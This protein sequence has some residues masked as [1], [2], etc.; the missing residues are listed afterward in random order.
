MATELFTLVAAVI[1]AIAG[2]IAVA[3]QIV[4]Q[5]RGE[6]RTAYREILHPLVPVLAENLHNLLASARVS[7]HA[8]RGESSRKWM[9][10]ATEARDE[11]KRV[12]P[13]LR[14][15]LE[16]VDRAV[17]QLTRLPNWLDQFSSDKGRQ[18]RLFDAADSLRTEIDSVVRGCYLEGRSPTQG[19]R[20]KLR[21]RC[22]RYE[23]IKG[24]VDTEKDD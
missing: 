16:G 14:Y 12:V 19:E 3:L 4:A 6:R 5:K 1:A 23:Q 8:G 7:M 2:I 21:L 24:S 17:Q 18:E 13:S 10:R 20:N 15:P 11:L 9:E 22:L